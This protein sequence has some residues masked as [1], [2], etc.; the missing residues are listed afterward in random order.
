[1]TKRNQQHSFV[2]RVLVGSAT[3]VLAVVAAAAMIGS[4]S[5]G[6][7]LQTAPTVKF[8]TLY[9]FT[10][11]NGDGAQPLAGVNVDPDSNL[12]GTTYSGGLNRQCDELGCGT[13]FKLDPT[14]KETFVYSLGNENGA[15]PHASLISDGK[16]NF[17]GAAS[18]GGSGGAAAGVVFRMDKTGKETVLYNFTG[19]SDG[20]QPWAGVILDPEG[21]LYGTT[22]RG[23]SSDHGTVFE[24]NTGGQ[25]TVL[26]SFPLES[27]GAEPSG[28]AEPASRLI[29]DANGN[30]YGTTVYGG[31]ATPI[32][33]GV[34]FKLDT[35]GN[36]TVLHTFVNSPDG[37]YPGGGMIPDASG[38]LYGT[39][40]DGG[41][42]SHCPEKL[43][44][45]I[46]FKL[47]PNW[48]GDHILHIPGCRERGRRCSFWRSDIGPRRQP[49]RHYHP[50]R[51]RELLPNLRMRNRVQD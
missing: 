23:G 51:F 6:A 37:C 15:S 49:V 7:M 33:C 25:E 38:N 50:R 32:A 17:Y 20:D 5:V 18:G 35:A 46:V 8:R 40:G 4:R 27:N 11:K 43:G 16:G 21:N 45:G 36:E 19:G 10:N 34:V 42:Y 30:L 2:I 1:M 22:W 9:K 28:G 44:C 48:S 47:D 3:L 13:V 24:V 14:G 31:A 41:N 39:T 12:Y 26:Y 29:R